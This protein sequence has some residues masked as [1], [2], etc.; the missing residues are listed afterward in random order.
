MMKECSVISIENQLQEYLISGAL[1]KG[2]SE[3]EEKSY[4]S[5]YPLSKT[6]LGVYLDCMKNPYTTLYN[7]PSVLKFTKAINPKKLADSV[8]KVIL[9][10]P[11][12]FTNLTT[13][14]DDVEQVYPDNIQFDIPVKKMTEKEIELLKKEFVKP[15]NFSK[16]PLFRILVVE[17][18]KNVYLFADFHHIIFDG[19]SYNIFLNQLKSAYEGEEEIGRAHV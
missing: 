7:I 4:K 17:T 10:H 2:T 3:T 1:A 6:Q 13:Q 5:L 19:A 11:Y 14:N 9:A 12:I 15:F 18:E 16:P 8:K